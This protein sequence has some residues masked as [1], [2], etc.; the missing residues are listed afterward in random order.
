[1]CV[2]DVSEP[3]ESLLVERYEERESKVCAEMYV[4]VEGEGRVLGNF[5]TTYS[6]KEF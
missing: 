6:A 4:W 5:R 2:S 1:M 3:M